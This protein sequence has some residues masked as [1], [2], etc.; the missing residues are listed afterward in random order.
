MRHGVRGGTLLL[1][2]LLLHRCYR[3][4]TNHITP[5]RYVDAREVG[6]RKWASHTQDTLLL[7]LAAQ[8]DTI[9]NATTRALQFS[10]CWW[11]MKRQMD[12]S[13]SEAALLGV[14][15]DRL[16][17]AFAGVGL[18]DRYEESLK[19]FQCATGYKEFAWRQLREVRVADGYDKEHDKLRRLRDD[20]KRQIAADPLVRPLL[21]LD[22][23]LYEA[24]VDVHKRE[25]KACNIS[26]SSGDSARLPLWTQAW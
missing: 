4:P 18:Y 21:S 11:T 7:Q 14:A 24:A 20:L 17:S 5:L 6:Y 19:L 13:G 2:P 22:I 12:A 16:H 25:L 10:P 1:L 8:K 3:L 23:S 26:R 9:F 15:M